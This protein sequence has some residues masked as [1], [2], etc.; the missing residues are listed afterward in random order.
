MRRII[1]IVI[2]TTLFGG[3]SES[4]NNFDATGTFESTE[5]TVS[6]EVVGRIL[7]FDIMEGS[8]VEQNEAVGTIDSVQ[9]HLQKLQLL[10]SISS[11]KSSRPSVVTQVAAVREKIGNLKIERKRIES[12]LE[13]NAATQKQLDD[14]NS[15]IIVL[16][17]Q[18]LAQKSSLNNSVESLN[19]QSSAMDIQVAQVVDKLG[20]CIVRSPISGI[21]LS[22]YAEAGEFSPIGK[23]LFK[24]ADMNN[25]YLK[26][27]ITS[28]QLVDLKLGQKIKVIAD[29][30]GDKSREYSGILSWIS[31]K[32]EFTPK[33]IQTKDEREN[34]V[35]AIKISVKNDGYIKLGMYGEVIF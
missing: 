17:R 25:V 20:K 31:D 34:Q 7:S 3:C 28:G 32:S 21:V 24:V 18:L 16:E 1:V 30:G 11:I 15:S 33:N 4:E 35:Y 14:I 2:F 27:Y 22:K 19:A 26:A 23:P 10:E 9:L 5:V 12:L 29:F 13:F 8:S 6:S